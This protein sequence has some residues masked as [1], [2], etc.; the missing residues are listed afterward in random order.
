M[1]KT[2]FGGLESH[3]LDFA[4]CVSA[5][6]L[7]TVRLHLK[8]PSLIPIVGNTERRVKRAL[9]LKWRN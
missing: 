9:A 7:P 1:E 4:I 5:V 2:S 6:Y 8:I 3:L